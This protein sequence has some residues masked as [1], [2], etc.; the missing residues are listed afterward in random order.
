MLKMVFYLNVQQQTKEG[1][2]KICV[3]GLTNS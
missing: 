1:G 3:K 2:E